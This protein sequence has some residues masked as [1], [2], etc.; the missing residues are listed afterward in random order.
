MRTDES[1]FE[2]IKKRLNTTPYYRFLGMEVSEV[3]PGF[4]RINLPFKRDLLQLAGAVHGGVTASLVDAAVA[5]A[6]I[7]SVAPETRITTIELK[8]NY[9]SPVKKEDVTAEGRII[10]KGSHTAVGD[11]EVRT[12]DGRL[13][14]KGMAT[15]MIFA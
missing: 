3:S 7:A 13:V 15:Y 9:V 2:S 11:V 10:H 6:L 5:V 4:A 14:A 1:H 8:V 12:K